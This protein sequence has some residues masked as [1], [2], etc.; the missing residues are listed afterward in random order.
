MSV[1]KFKLGNVKMQDK[2]IARGLAKAMGNIG[3]SAA[4]IRDAMS[5]GKDFA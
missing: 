4:Q 5:P 3:M 2:V 1:E